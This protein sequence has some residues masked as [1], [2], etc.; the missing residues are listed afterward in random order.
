MS[1]V[2]VVLVSLKP[3]S[4]AKA[5]TSSGVKKLMKGVPSRQYR[6]FFY[7]E[8]ELNPNFVCS[9]GGSFTLPF[10]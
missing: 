1:F 9:G 2:D 3:A 5:N 6:G 4:W 10:N 7:A 8:R